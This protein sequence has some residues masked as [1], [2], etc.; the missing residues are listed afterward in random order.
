MERTLVTGFRAGVLYTIRA[1][2]FDPR[3]SNRDI[4]RFCAWC[5]T[6]QHIGWEEARAIRVAEALVLRQRLEAL[7]W[8]EGSGL[9]A[10]MEE[11][12]EAGRPTVQ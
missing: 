10:D 4:Q 7:V 6:A 1:R 2:A 12:E 11:L 8:P 3:W 5:A 9:E